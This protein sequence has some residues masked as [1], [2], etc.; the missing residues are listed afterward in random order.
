M[1]LQAPDI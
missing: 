1:H